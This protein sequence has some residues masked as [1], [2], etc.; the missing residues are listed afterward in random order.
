MPSP[1]QDSSPGPESLDR[2]FLS[3]WRLSWVALVL[4]ALYATIVLN[5]ALP[6]RLADPAWQL[7]LY[8]AVMNASAFPLVGLALLHLSSDLNPDN[9][10]LARRAGFFAGLAVPIALGFLLLI[11]LQGYLLWQQSSSAASGATTQLDRQ[12]R[13]LAS[14]RQAVQQAGSVAELQKRFS[15]LQGPTLG[16]AE[17]ALPLSQ[18]KTQLNVALEQAAQTLR[19]RRASLPSVDPTSLLLLALRNGFACLALA[20]GFAALGQR[21][22][23][24][25]PLLMEWQDGLDR[26]RFLRRRPSGGRGQSPDFDYLNRISD[27]DD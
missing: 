5:A 11:P 23:A 20:V 19:S 26:L 17:Q 7:R 4:L 9:E 25:A 10:T 3:P 1:A 14:L 13:T 24:P 2:P 15:A 18:L 8:N 6:L 21:H 22:R 12:E 27:K 16:P